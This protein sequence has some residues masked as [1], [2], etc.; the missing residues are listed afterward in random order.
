VSEGTL[1]LG[2]VA[3]SSITGNTANCA[4]TVTNLTST[5]NLAVGQAV[6]GTGIGTNAVIVSIDSPTQVTVSVANSG[7]GTGTTFGFAA[8][9]GSLAST[10]IEVKPGAF[11]DVSSVAGFSL[12][13]AQTLKGGGTVIGAM[14]VAGTLSPGTSPGTLNTGSQSWLTGAAYNWQVYDATGAAGSGYDT[15]AINGT[16]DLSALLSA[17]FAINLWSLS[18]IGPDANGNAINFNAAVDQAWTLASASG[19]ITGFEASDFLVNLEASNGTAGFGNNTNGGTF[20][21]SQSG[22]DLVLTFTAASVP[23]PSTVLLGGSG[24]LL[25]LLHRRRR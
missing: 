5:A 1:K 19:G 9:S 6:S 10:S 21:V 17:G 20:S 13:A 4:F 14:S 8:N 22:N 25:L 7:A 23:E 16:L 11:L 24:I 18:A 3:G 12:G 2:A 15:I